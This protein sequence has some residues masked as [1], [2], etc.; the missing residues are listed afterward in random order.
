MA[1]YKEV[2]GINNQKLSADPPAP[3][4]GQVW[5]N[6]TSGALKGLKFNSGSWSTGGNLNT[7]RAYLAGIGTQTAGLATGGETPTVTGATETYNGT[8]WT[9]VNDLNTARYVLGGAGA[10]NTSALVFGGFPAPSGQT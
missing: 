2:K 3:I 9:E 8:S 1:A 10:D 4:E 6:T 5:Y 7:A